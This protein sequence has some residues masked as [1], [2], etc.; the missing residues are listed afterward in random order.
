[1]IRV[2]L[3][4]IAMWAIILIMVFS[5]LPAMG[6]VMEDDPRWNCRTMGNHTCGIDP[7]WGTR[8][9][10]VNGRLIF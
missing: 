9:V 3:A 1:M 7:Y 4:M 6:S 5:A 8:S 2:T 10:T